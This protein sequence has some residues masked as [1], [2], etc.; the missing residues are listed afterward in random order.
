MST[1]IVDVFSELRRQPAGF[2]K[3]SDGPGV[4]HL[5]SKALL[6][7]NDAGYEKVW[8]R[9]HEAVAEARRLWGEPAYE[10]PGRRADL[11]P[12]G[13]RRRVYGEPDDQWRTG[14]QGDCPS[15]DE[16]FGQSYNQALRIG[17]WKR[18]GF[19]QA[20]MVTGHDANTLQILR[21]VVAEAREEAD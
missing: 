2:H 14:Y 21:L 20:I 17:W 1:G 11:S 5:G 13:S 12:D 6:S 15:S 8:V 16:Y 4:V 18:E 7:S 10:G 9:Y 19:V 3:V